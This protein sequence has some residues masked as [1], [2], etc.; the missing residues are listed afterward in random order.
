MKKFAMWWW[1]SPVTS[2]LA[3]N[4]TLRFILKMQIISGKYLAEMKL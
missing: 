2:S 3:R 1:L 4:K